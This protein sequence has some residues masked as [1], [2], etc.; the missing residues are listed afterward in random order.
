MRRGTSTGSQVLDQIP[1]KKREWP[2][3]EK[4][5]TD[6]GGLGWHSLEMASGR[7]TR[8]KAL[9]PELRR[10]GADGAARRRRSAMS[11]IG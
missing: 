1:K 2:C 5:E 4:R 3:K 11:E 9:P 10:G 7:T 6:G 8:G